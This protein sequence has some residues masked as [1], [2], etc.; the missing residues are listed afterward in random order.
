MLI[1]FQSLCVSRCQTVTISWLLILIGVIPASGATPHWIVGTSKAPEARQLSKSFSTDKPIQRAEIK[2]AADFCAASLTI[3]GQPVISVEPYCP[4]QV[5][6]VTRHVRRGTN[7]LSVSV[8][9][10]PG[11]AAIA[12]SL[13]LRGTDGMVTTIVSD[14]SWTGAE[15]RG[16]VPT[17]QWGLERR[18]AEV[19]PFDNYEQWRQA[20]GTAGEKEPKFWLAAGF[21]VSRVRQAEPDE[22]SWIA[23]AFDSQGRVTISREDNGLVRMTLADD[24]R[25]VTRVEPI[26]VDLPECRGLQFIQ[27]HLYANANNARS[28]YRLRIDEDGLAQDVERLREFPGGLGHGRNDLTLGPDGLIYSIHGDSVEAPGE[29]IVDRTSPLRESRRGSPRQEA[30]VVRGDRDGKKWELVCTGL[31]NPY[32]IA[33]NKVGD[34]FTYDADNEFDMGTPW[35]RPTRIVQLV[36]GA[37]Y[38]YRRAQGRWPPEFADHPDN[39]LP[40]ID[41][42]RGSPTAV[43][44]GTHLDFPSPYREAMFA[45]DWAYGRVLAVHLTPRGAGYRASLELFMQGKPLNVT[46]LSA[47]PDGALYLITGGR[48]TRSALY[49]VAYT[50]NPSPPTAPGRHEVEVAEFSARRRD[51]RLELEARHV[52]LSDDDIRAGLEHLADKDPLIRHAARIALEQRPKQELFAR[53]DALPSTDKKGGEGLPL[54]ARLELWESISRTREPDRVAR[55]VD[56][57]LALPSA[58]LDLSARFAIV[59]LYGECISVVPTKVAADGDAI[60]KQIRAFWPDPAVEGLRVSPFGTNLELRRRLALLLSQLGD[61]TLVDRVAR[62]LFTESAQEDRLM[63]LL[64]LRSTSLGWTSGTRRDYFAALRDARQFVGGEGLPTFID[65]LKSDS[66]ASL[67][68]EERAQV[69]DL[70]AANPADD[71]P[72]PPPRRKVATWKL[73]DLRPLGEQQE[74][75]VGNAKRGA[76]IFREALCSRCHRA[77]ATGPAIGPDLTFVAR[78]F[79]RADMLEAMIDPSRSVAEN[80]RNLSVATESGQVYVGRIVSAGDYR[81][82]KLRLNVDPLRPGH[83]VEID[84]KEVAEQRLHD[85][86]PMP[87]GLLDGFTRDEIADLLAYLEGEG[88]TSK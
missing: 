58:D 83:V 22:G 79:S 59:F 56:E 88:R 28:M 12:L 77:G 46:D 6:D 63:G 87:Q 20:S 45:L 30:Y 65:R 35:Y 64:A 41:V 15:S 38:G 37:D 39:A 55:L 16:L 11:P 43:M 85:S 86:S 34:F 7:E 18:S 14:E 78:R 52:A 74:G 26:N 3:N 2:L 9:Q 8:T 5:V 84:K 80:Y 29:P 50:A 68:V 1:R 81:G 66:L 19:S 54:R 25:S 40:V 67:G 53:Y 75:P 76:E 57:L 42:G 69:E 32:G 82:E 71:E 17:E 23:M 51:L 31:R 4:L 60:V 10:I 33:F 49:R 70:L 48:K 27:G 73:D 24:R 47:G 44:F 62:T 61:P 36:S 21:E 13:T 72:L